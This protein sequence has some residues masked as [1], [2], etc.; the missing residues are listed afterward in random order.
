MLGAVIST[1]KS[2]RATVDPDQIDLIYNDPALVQ[3]IGGNNR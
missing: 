1:V 2:V 3:Q